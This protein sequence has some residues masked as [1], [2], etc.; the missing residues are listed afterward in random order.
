MYLER[1]RDYISLAI[2]GFCLSY[3]T[4][5]ALELEPSVGVG[6]QYTDNAQ[7]TLDEEV[8]DLIA[9]T[10]AAAKLNEDEGRLKYDVE[11]S[12]KKDNYTQDTYEDKRYF[13]L[14]ASADWEMMR[15]RFHWTLSNNFRQRTINSLDSNTPDNLQDANTFNFGARIIFPISGRQKLTLIPLFSQY[16]YEQSS[17]DNRQYSIKA[18]WDYQMFRL[19]HV[20]INLGARK[21]N[22]FDQDITGTTFS[23]LSIDL[24]KQQ[25]SS[26]FSI[27]LGATN[28]QREFDEGST[29]FVGSVDW[30]LDLSSRSK[31][32]TVVSTSITDTSSVS[33]DATGDLDDVE[34]TVDVVR[35]SKMRL[36]YVRADESLHSSLWI[37]Y[38]KLKYEVSPNDREIRTFGARLSYP[39]TQLLSGGV[40]VGYNHT[41]QLDTLREDKTFT[42]GT[43]IKYLLTAKLHT[44]VDIRYRTKE[45]AEPSVDFDVLRLRNY[46]EFSIF[47]S[48]IYGF[49]DIS[50]V[51]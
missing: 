9:T 19:T 30:L 16:Y 40:S 13:N 29:G 10:Y 20:G 11:T 39:V 2:I 25:A 17:T 26:K 41:T 6:V 27:N 24:K 1:R 21:V 5:V 22:Y 4:V 34:L 48:L 37:D 35:S 47:A 44:T 8:S 15:E 49:G 18:N 14:A 23:N 38:R 46:D 45:S 32:N 51:R 7:L 31:L 12:I 36:A 42:F 33:R 3:K 28:V 50:R 43:N